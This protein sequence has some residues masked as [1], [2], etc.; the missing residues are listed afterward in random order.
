MP[1]GANGATETN[2]ES[3]PVGAAAGDAGGAE[4]I[5]GSA[6]EP[7]GGPDRVSG[8]GASREIGR[9]CLGRIIKKACVSP[10]ILVVLALS[11]NSLFG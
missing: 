4:P 5:R 1:A 10:A 9:V 6:S 8:G 11:L 2:G 3:E 7:T